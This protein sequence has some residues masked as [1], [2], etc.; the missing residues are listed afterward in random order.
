MLYPLNVFLKNIHRFLKIFLWLLYVYKM[1]LVL[2]QMKT[3]FVTC[4]IIFLFF[5][6]NGFQHR[7]KG[8]LFQ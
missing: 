1:G 3:L 4:Y 7:S 6:L 8:R 2:Y 5:I